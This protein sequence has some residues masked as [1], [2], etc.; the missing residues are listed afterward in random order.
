MDSKKPLVV[1]G[2]GFAGLAF[3]K[4]IDRKNRKVILID[5]DNYNSFPPLFYQVASAGLDSGSICFA[6]RRE[7]RSRRAKGC[8]YHMGDVKRI[9]SDKHV[10]YTQFEAIEYSQLVIA[11]GTTNNFFGIDGLEK[12]VYTL[13]STTQA[14]RCRNDILERLERA[15]V[16]N[17]PEYR[18]RI[19]TFTIIGGGPAGVE[20]AG[21]LGEMKRYILRREYP[22]I[23]P[24]EVTVTL[25]E[26]TNRLLGAMSEYSSRKALD[27]LGSLM[28]NVKLGY[29][30]D[31]YKDNVITFRN[32]EKLPSELVIWTA[33]VTSNSFEFI[34]HKPEIGHGGR[35][36]VDE[37]NR[38]AGLEDVFALGDICLMTSDKWPHGHPQ[39]A[40]VALQQAKNLAHNL[41]RGQFSK[42]FVYKDKGTMAT[43]GRNRAVADL[44]HIR[45]HGRIA[46]FA[47]MGV[48]L[49]SILGMRNRLT[50]FITWVWAYFTYSASLRLIL[51]PTKYPLRDRHKD[52]SDA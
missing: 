35:L 12:S 38:V 33:G 16:S 42:A 13:K 27:Y 39:V 28:V 24:D 52:I 32:G 1:I 15:A 10:I 44:N 9:D 7:M 11:A 21:A 8:I 29:Q 19:L 14:I 3:I 17:D 41:R 40:Q 45:L 4:H 23:S 36:I 37:Y 30:L 22:G 51:R 47:W 2:G 34:G 49:M 25:I 50:V 6:L 48:H 31:S 43:V 20:I 26:G 5:K 18:R 46:W